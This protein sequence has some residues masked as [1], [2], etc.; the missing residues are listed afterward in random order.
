[1]ATLRKA[2]RIQDAIQDFE[3]L[4]LQRYPAA[5]F[6]VVKG[7]DPPGTYLEVQV[8]GEVFE[9]AFDGIFQTIEDRLVAILVEGPLALYVMPVDQLSAP[10]R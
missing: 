10:S 9:D 8:D 2:D 7:F 5:K 6:E 3:M 1:M 4:I